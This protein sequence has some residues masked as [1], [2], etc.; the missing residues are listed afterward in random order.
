MLPSRSRLERW[1]PDSLTTASGS[2]RTRGNAV[3]AAV[4]QLNYRIKSLPDTRDWSG[5]AHD[6]A[7]EM[8]DRANDQTTRFADYTSAIASA[9]ADGASSI[10][11]TRKALLDK[12]DEIDRG[13]LQDS[14]SWVVLIKPVPMSAE[15]VNAL[16]EQAAAEQATI[17]Q[18][19]LAVGEAD[20]ETAHKITSAAQ[21]FGFVA[22]PTGGLPGMMIPGAQE[23]GDQVPNPSSPLGLFQQSVIRGEDMS[24]SVRETIDEVVNDDEPRRTIIMQD[25]SKHVIWKYGINTVNDTHYAPDGS[26]ISSTSSWTNILDGVSHT[27]IRWADGT[28]FNASSTPDGVYTAA[29]TLPDGSHP[30]L[31]PNNPIFSGVVPQTVG[32]ALTGLEAHT[33]RGGKLPMVSLEAA[34]NI[35]KNAKWG[36]PALGLMTT[37][38]SVLSAP[39]PHDMCVEGVAGTFGIVGDVGG[40]YFG[41]GVGTLAPPGAQVITVPLMAVGGAYY[42]SQWMSALGRKVGEAFCP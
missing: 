7:A 14:D 37:A 17:N 34:E 12:A 20:D 40:G 39:T 11:Q 19:L 23:P 33:G 3:D 31:P 30:V 1:A 6:A 42:G 8:F 36:G 15:K 16:M 41:A 5:Q 22:P 26:M 24:T 13:E 29:F 32:G 18:L 9:V 21:G 4:D 35:G 38:Y 10:G 2:I 28:V 27:D 25:G